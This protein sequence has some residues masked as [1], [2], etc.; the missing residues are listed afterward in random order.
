MTKGLNDEIEYDGKNMA[1]GI[2]KLLFCY[3]YQLAL[4]GA[5]P[6][7]CYNQSRS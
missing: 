5:P 1:R 6:L 3:C 7:T 2:Y 4:S